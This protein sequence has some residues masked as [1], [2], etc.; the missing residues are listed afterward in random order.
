M[1]INVNSVSQMFISHIPACKLVSLFIGKKWKC[2]GKKCHS[3]MYM[4][5]FGFVYSSV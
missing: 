1:L 3:L 2:I 5:I 4:Y